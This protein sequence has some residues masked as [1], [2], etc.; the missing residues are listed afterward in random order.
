M[1]EKK[2]IRKVSGEQRAKEKFSSVSTPEL[3]CVLGVSAPHITQL[4]DQGMPYTFGKNKKDSRFNLIDCVQ[5]Y[6][7]HKTRKNRV[8]PIKEIECD[9]T[10]SQLTPGEK[11]HV[12]QEMI[13]IIQNE[14]GT[15]RVQAG[16]VLLELDAET[17]QREM[18]QAVAFIEIENLDEVIQ[19]TGNISVRCPKCKT[20]LDFK[21]I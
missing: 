14:T 2:V 10:T 15:A 8:K 6:I 9:L 16:K 4:K 3:A 19:A 21:A 13:D 17:K 18:P 12:K 20:D 5:W 1:Q 11:A 7:E